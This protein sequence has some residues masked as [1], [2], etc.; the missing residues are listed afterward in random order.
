MQISDVAAARNMVFTFSQ[1]AVAVLAKKW[2]LPCGE[3]EK[4]TMRTTCERG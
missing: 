4:C 1:Q 2:R 3:R